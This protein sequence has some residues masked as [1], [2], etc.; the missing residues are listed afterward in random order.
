[1]FAGSAVIFFR[2]SANR[3]ASNA[4][5]MTAVAGKKNVLA[6]MAP[7]KGGKLLPHLVGEICQ[8]FL[9]KML[10]TAGEK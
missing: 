10:F 4:V 9:K 1:M 5:V 6:P 2:N 7:I 8:A 3:K